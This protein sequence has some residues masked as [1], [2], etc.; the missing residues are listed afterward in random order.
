MSDAATTRLAGERTAEAR[1]IEAGLPRFGIDFDESNLPQEAALD[2]WLSFEKGCY[3]G[4]EY[5]VRLA[6][7]GQVS[8]RLSG[9]LVDSE[10]PPTRGTPVFAGKDRVGEITSAEHSPRLVSVVGLGY[11]RRGF[12][13]AGTALQVG[14][15][16]D[17]VPAKVVALPFD[18]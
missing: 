11:L 8:K 5:V 6:H 9:M 4:Q 15:S 14:E 18:S 2:D 12:L 10:S 17:E 13:E 16:P 1:R 7:R 3:I